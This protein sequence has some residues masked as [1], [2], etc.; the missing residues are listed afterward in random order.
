MTRFVF[1]LLVCVP[2]FAIGC[3]SENS[4]MIENATDED[5]A[6]YERLIAEANGEVEAQDEDGSFDE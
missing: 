6:N 4:T 3:S 5:V 2:L 1:A